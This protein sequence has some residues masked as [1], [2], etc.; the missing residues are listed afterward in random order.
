MRAYVQ[1]VKIQTPCLCMPHH[2][3]VHVSRYTYPAHKI[4]SGAYETV[5]G[6]SHTRAETHSDTHWHTWTRANTHK[7]THPQSGRD[8][9]PLIWSRTISFSSILRTENLMSVRKSSTKW[10]SWGLD[11][12]YSAHPH[13]PFPPP[14]F[15]NLPLANPT[16]PLIFHRTYVC[17]DLWARGGE[18]VLALSCSELQSHDQTRE[19]LLNSS[20]GRVAR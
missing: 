8:P 17:R 20:N 7:H 2:A 18:G 12:C 6:Y 16:P 19:R 13:T 5:W 11:A 9:L 1:V 10:E 3:C 14:L 15:A 4:G